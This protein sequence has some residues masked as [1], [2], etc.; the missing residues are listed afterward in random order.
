MPA[1]PPNESPMPKWKLVIASHDGNKDLWPYFFHFLWRFWPE[2]PTP[3]YLI[4]NHTTFDSPK[5]KTIHTG[6]DRAWSDNIRD[7]LVSIQADYVIFM[8]DDMF[9]NTVVN[10]DSLA[11]IYREFIQRQGLF[12]ELHVRQDF[13]PEAGGG[14]LRHIPDTSLI[15]GINC[16]YWRKD[17]LAKACVPGRTIWK[18]DAEVRRLNREQGERMFYTNCSHPEL[19][20]VESVKGGFWKPEG[21]DYL[22]KNGMRP[23][24]LLRPCPLQGR[25]W[26][27]KMYRSLLKRGMKIWR[28]IEQ[29]KGMRK[30]V[31]PFQVNES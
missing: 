8:L 5:V 25:D 20:Y 19:D 21:I 11:E 17:F 14:R 6:P 29:K 30:M 24:L 31:R 7:S 15:A 22:A 13:E 4:T 26:F 23:N 16:A 9:L 12:C 27:S 3:V 1:A 18:V 28:G 2:V 10:T